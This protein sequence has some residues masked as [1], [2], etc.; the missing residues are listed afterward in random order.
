M[1]AISCKDLTKEYEGGGEPV[2]VLK[3]VSLSVDEGEF[4]AIMGQSGSGKSTLLHCLGLLETPTAGDVTILGRCAAGLNDRQRADLR[5]D[6]MGFVFQSFY[7]VPGLTVFENV[8]LPMLI[9]RRREGRDRRAAQLLDRVG[10]G[11]RL[12]HRPSQLS[13][14][15]QQRVAIARALA[16]SPAMLLLDE[17]T[18][19][20]DS[21]TGERVL[22][23]LAEINK[24]EGVTT[25]M[26]TH[27]MEAAG[28]CG[29]VITIRDGRV[30][31]DSP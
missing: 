24:N 25:L 6:A 18:G 19:N 20:L 12:H 21:E 13:G 2:P 22:A 11:H 15:E 14:G 3:G 8:L 5:R 1:A 4:V 17:P 16:N 28:R 29:R 30:A 26:V 9:R 31:E 10:L 27:S 7:L 23:L